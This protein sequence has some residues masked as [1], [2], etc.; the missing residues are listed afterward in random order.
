MSATTSDAATEGTGQPVSEAT[1]ETASAKETSDVSTERSSTEDS[2]EY[3]LESDPSIWK[4]IPEEHKELAKK[5]GEKVFKRAYTKKSQE[6]AAE[7]KAKELEINRLREQ[8]E[9]F[10]RIAQGVLSDPTQYE[11]YRKQFGYVKPE[12]SVPK[13][14]TVEDLLSYQ[15][16]KFAKEKKE[17]LNSVTRLTADQIRAYDAE[18]RYSKAKLELETSDPVFRHYKDEILEIAKSKKYQDMYN[19]FNEKDV[20]SSVVKDF[21]FKRDKDLES[22]KQETLESLKLKKQSST[23]APQKPVKTTSQGKAKSKEEMIQSVR[24]KFG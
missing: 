4:D 23:F 11:A 7:L 6:K 14:E 2:A 16:Q 20:L 15:E 21:K 1:T 12:Q 19:G 22:T 18:Q 3:D 24:S 13:I 5:Y 8:T 17:L 9:S 10:K